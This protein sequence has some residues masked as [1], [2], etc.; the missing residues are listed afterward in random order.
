M[1][2]LTNVRKTFDGKRFVLDG[3]SATFRPGEYTQIIGK[4]G[5]GKSTLLN[6]IGL[7]DGQYEGEIT[8]DGKDISK[9]SDMKI[10]RIRSQR[11]GFIFQAYNLV[12]H[13]TAL[14]NIYMPILYAKKKFD[15][16]YRARV[17]GLIEKL[18]IGRIAETQIQYLSGGEKQR[19]SIARA[20]SLD[21]DVIL[22]DEPT[23]NLDAG[24]SKIT[25]HVLKKLAMEGKTV[26]LVTHNLHDD[27]GA[28]RILT[29]QDGVLK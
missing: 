4:S 27:L 20:L 17:A 10:S 1:I 26:I 11:I 6:L 9:L 3:L 15:S 21:P 22:A 25:F 19:V 2:E 16:E 24:N 18:E 28:D 7:L 14:E 5:A 8:L 23:G 13:M 12:N 29:L